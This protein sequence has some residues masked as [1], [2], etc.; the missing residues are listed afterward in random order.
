MTTRSIIDIYMNGDPYGA[1]FEG[2]QSD[3][4]GH[5]WYF[6]GDIGAKSREWWRTYARQI[7]AILRYS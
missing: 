3:D 2:S 6:R 5:S 4:G 7:N 1:G